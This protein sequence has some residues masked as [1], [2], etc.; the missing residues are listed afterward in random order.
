MMRVAAHPEL[1]KGHGHE[2]K[3]HSQV[4]LRVDTA[5]RLLTEVASM[6]VA[7]FL[8]RPK[9]RYVERYSQPEA[10]E[11]LDLEQQLELTH[12]VAGLPSELTD[13]DLEAKLFDLLILRLQLALLRAEPSFAGLRKRVEEIAGLLEEMDSIPMVR[14]Q[15]GLIQEIQTDDFWQ[16]VTT[17]ILENVRK[18]LRALV[19]LIER[20]KRKPVYSDFIDEI[21][22][23]QETQLP[24][25]S[26]ATFARFR[27]KARAFL[28]EH[29]NHPTIRK[30]R[31]N[32]AL[33]AHDLSELE[34]LLLQA[35]IGT[36]QDLIQ[37]K[38]AS[39]G[40]GL[41]L[42]SLV[43]LDRQA[44]MD[45]F[46]RFLVGRNPTSHQIEFIDLIV[47]H[48]TEQGYMDAARLYE[49]PFTDLNPMGV[50]GIFPSEQVGEL[51]GI[52]KEIRQHAAAA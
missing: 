11:K 41:F 5:E 46:A 29:E 35:G 16:D 48:L 6:N 34:R 50:E 3:D 4:G 47:N 15:M 7:N 28:R 49:S 38:E 27:D 12:E 25:F 30:V 40:F 36:A 31:Q 20:V 43:G 14:E 1:D 45:A 21:G 17:P 32:E 24:G 2:R 10:W 51:L 37:A 22:I 39:E 26:H 23:E 42:R 18:K 33:T 52:L 13:P 8:V 9:R 19:K 44:A